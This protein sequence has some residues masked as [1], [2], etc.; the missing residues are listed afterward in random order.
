MPHSA[1]VS[2][3]CADRTGLIA[4]ITGCLFDLG[5]NLGDTNFAVLGTGAEFTA[6]C[7]LPGE[8]SLGEV[9]A[10]LRGLSALEVAK[11]TVAPFTL[12][13]QHGPSGIITHRITVEGGDQPGLVARLCEVFVQFKANIVRLAAEKTPA[14][15]Y[16]IR[17]SVSIPDEA[18]ASCI[19]TVANTAE[20]LQMV[21]EVEALAGN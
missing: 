20:G 19:A 13:P 12:D 18:A 7:E 21:C 16:A 3:F 11:I 1:L 10:A 14:G 2:V 5:V 8:A 9:E 6:V 4:A 17:F 15:A